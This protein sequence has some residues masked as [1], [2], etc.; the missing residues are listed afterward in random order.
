MKSSKKI[1]KYIR[2]QMKVMQ[3]DFREAYYDKVNVRE[4]QDLSFTSNTFK[5]DTYTVALSVSCG[6]SLYKQFRT[7]EK[8]GL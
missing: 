7:L 2:K 8:E 5:H 6:R 1:A 4:K 3:L